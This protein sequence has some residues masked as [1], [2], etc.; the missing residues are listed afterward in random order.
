MAIDWAG[1]FQFSQ[2]DT[3]DIIEEDGLIQGS[4]DLKLGDGKVLDISGNK[5]VLEFNILSQTI[6]LTGWLDIFADS[7][8][9]P[10]ITGTVSITLFNEGEGNRLEV[11]GTYIDSSGATQSFSYTDTDLT[12]RL[13]SRGERIRLDASD[14]FLSTISSNSN[15]DRLGRLEFEKTGS[16]NTTEM[17][18]GKLPLGG[19]IDIFLERN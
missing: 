9:V 4:T 15:I 7:V 19:K 11:S 1:F 12:A 17:D 14:R 2:N 16:P 8:D 18:V 6:D 10:K 13:R 5:L 3:F